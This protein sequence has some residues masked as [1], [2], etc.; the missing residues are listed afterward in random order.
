MRIKKVLNNNAA[1]VVDDGQEKI[2]IGPGI[3]FNKG[4][5][6]I[7]SP[8]KIE[9]IFVLE[10]KDKLEQLLRQIPQEHFD[11][12]EEIISYAEKT[13]NVSL[14]EH[15]HLVLTDHISFAIQKA[16]EGINIEN[17]LL[18]EIRILYP[19]EFAIGQWA[20]QHIKQ[21]LGVELPEDEAGFIAIHI[22]TMKPH[23]NNLQQTLR[24]TTIL[25]EMMHVIQEEM[26]F[27]LDANDWSY[28]RLMIHLRF[29]LTNNQ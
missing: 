12:S 29:A 24:T 27:R 7:V 14:N 15:I 19:E 16:Q 23:S 10:E 2:A 8:Q 22:H 25:Q 13:L 6:D 21:T 18:H 3:G 28:Q 26:G 5:N 4:K 1:I 11:I 17:K 20:I 9:K